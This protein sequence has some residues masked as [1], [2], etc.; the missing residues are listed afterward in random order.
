MILQLKP[1]FIGISQLA[2]IHY[3]RYLT[4]KHAGWLIERVRS[5]TSKETMHKRILEMLVNPTVWYM[6]ICVYI[7]TSTCVYIYNMY[8]YIY[9]CPCKYQNIHVCVYGYTYI[10]LTCMT[11]IFAAF[12]QFPTAEKH[13]LNSSQ[14]SKISNITRRDAA[15]LKIGT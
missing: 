11:L 10:I 8:I 12:P 4:F 13:S 1:P 3:Q 14:P 15:P 2:M 5:K 9:I 7:S 6:C